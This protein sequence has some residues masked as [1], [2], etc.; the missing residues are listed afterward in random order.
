MYRQNVVEIIFCCAYANLKWC[1]LSCWTHVTEAL[2]SRMMDVIHVITP[3]L[4]STVLQTKVIQPCSQCLFVFQ[5]ARHES[6]ATWNWSDEMELVPQLERLQSITKNSF[7]PLESSVHMQS[8]HL[9]DNGHF[10]CVRFLLFK[11]DSC[12]NLAVLIFH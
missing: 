12:Q 11:P 8:R 1:L 3:F 2:H 10:S 5:K 4:F 7:L 6:Y 9:H